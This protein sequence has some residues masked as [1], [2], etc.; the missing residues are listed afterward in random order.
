MKLTNKLLGFLNRVFNKSPVDALVLRLS[1]DGSMSWSVADGAL[2]TTVTGGSGAALTVDLSAYTI[3]SLATFL[4][5]QPGYSVPYVT[6]DGDLLGLSARALI[7]GGADIATSNGDHILAYTSV[8]WAMMEPQAYEL[9][10]AKQA[11]ADAPREL[12]VPTAQGEWLDELGSQ[13]G[14]LRLQGE[15]DNDYATRMIASIGKPLGNNVAM[16]TAINVVTGGLQAKVVDAPAQ[17]FTTPYAGTSYGLFDVVYSIALDGADTFDTYTARVR[18]VVEAYRDA[19]TH[20]RSLIVS[21]DLYDAYDTNTIAD[22]A[23]SIGIGIDPVETVQLEG[24][25][26]NGQYRRDGSSLG[27][28]DGLFNFDGAILYGLTPGPLISFNNSGEDLL[29]TLTIAGSVQPEERI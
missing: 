13:Y 22:G 6:D 19:G 17:A 27:N 7:D 24:K 2:T 5:A 9:S 1:Y 28:F 12:S 4:A 23:L 14:I 16:E 15:S 8:L 20:M 3:A 25:R 10:I 29:I 21:G 18:A 11:I 26:H